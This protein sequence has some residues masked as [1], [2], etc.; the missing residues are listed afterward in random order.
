MIETLEPIKNGQNYHACLIQLEGRGVLISGRSGAGK[1]SLMLSLLEAAQ[2]KNQSVNFVSDDQVILTAENG[3]LIGSAP[4]AIAGKVEIFGFGILD[5]PNITNSQVD[6]LVYLEPDEALERLP[7]PMHS[8]LLD[9][10]VP[11]ISVP[12]RHEQQAVRI[13]LAKLTSLFH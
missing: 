8:N 4:I 5:V 12:E 13:V 2:Q 6:L 3:K 9:I 10:N 1:T 7:D 11:C